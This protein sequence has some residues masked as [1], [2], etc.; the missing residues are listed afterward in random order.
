MCN[1]S[2]ACDTQQIT[3][4]DRYSGVYHNSN[5]NTDK[6]TQTAKKTQY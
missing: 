3:G 5:R 1:D 2:D 4:D 6:L